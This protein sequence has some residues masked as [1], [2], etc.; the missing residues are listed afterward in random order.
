MPIVRD[1]P[2]VLAGIWSATWQSGLNH[3][4]AG[5]VVASATRCRIFVWWRD[6]QTSG[7]CCCCCCHWHF[8]SVREFTALV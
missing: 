7:S 8:F 6:R 1:V 2:R 3:Q 5:V 4:P